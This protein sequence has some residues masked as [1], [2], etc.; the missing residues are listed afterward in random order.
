MY[1]QVI[2]IQRQLEVF[3]VRCAAHFILLAL[4]V[5]GVLGHNFYLLNDH[6]LEHGL[7]QCHRI[8]CFGGHAGTQFR[9]RVFATAQR[10]QASV[11]HIRTTQQVGQTVLMLD[12]F[13]QH[14]LCFCQRQVFGADP[15]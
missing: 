10:H 1:L 11:S 9:P 5:A 8:R 2:H 7:I 4:N 13:A 12:G 3:V 6:R 15:E 14:A